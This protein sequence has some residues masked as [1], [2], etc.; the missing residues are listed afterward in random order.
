MIASFPFSF[1]VG[2]QNQLGTEIHRHSLLSS[3]SIVLLF[4]L[5]LV[6]LKL[7][8]AGPPAPPVDTLVIGTG[9]ML[10]DHTD[11]Y[12]QIEEDWFPFP[13]LSLSYNNFSWYGPRLQY[14]WR[15]W[16]GGEV[17]SLVEYVFDG[18][19][20]LPKTV[21][22]GMADRENAFMMGFGINQKL[23]NFLKLTFNNMHEP[24]GIHGGSI[25]S[26]GMEW[27]FGLPGLPFIR[28]KLSS[29]AEYWSSSYANYYYGV[30]HHEGGPSRPSYEVKKTVLGIGGLGLSMPLPGGLRLI[31][32][33]KYKQLPPTIF[34]SPIIKKD[35][36]W[37]Y[38]A[39]VVYSFH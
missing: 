33:V 21:M 5:I 6:P 11:I 25:F 32:N 4:A 38:S 15:A 36:Q 26:L 27:S 2:T 37:N 34:D 24:F 7:W 16:E 8:G 13:M 1:L 18:Y 12:D 39:G 23:T 19:E 31:S 35:H 3:P 9:I 22:E 28:M 10:A 29:A 14:S 30:P 20:A 17:V